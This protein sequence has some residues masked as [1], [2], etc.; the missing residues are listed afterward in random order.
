MERS[1][2][3]RR[4]Q[5]WVYGALLTLGGLVLLLGVALAITSENLKGPLLRVIIAHSGRPVRVDGEFTAHLLARHP[6]ITATQ[7]VIG[8]PAWM[9]PGD[10]AQIG[11]LSIA[12]SWQ[13][14]AIPL[15]IQTLQLENTT[16]H[17]LRDASGHSN[18]HQRQSGPGSG[19]PLLRSLSM[20]EA[21]V[22]LNDERRHLQF[23][24]AVSVTETPTAEGPPS[25]RI[26]ARG[27]LNGRSAVLLIVGDPLALVERA[28]PY[29]FSLEERS[30]S[31]HLSALGSIERPFDFR[32]LQGTFT[33]TGPDMKDLYYLVGLN[34]PETG[35]FR[36]SGKL[37]RQGKRFVYSDLAAHT[38]QSD[39]SGTL[40]VDSSG[41][42]SSVEGELS[43]TA[44]VLAD[45]GARAAGHAAEPVQPAA[46]RVPDTPLRISGLR[47]TDWRLKLRAQALTLGPATLHSV[48]ALL[49]VDQGVLSVER[50]KATLADGTVAGDVRLDAARD[51]PRAELALSLS[52]LQLEQLHGKGSEPPLAGPLSARVQL[53]GE[54]KS[55][56]ELAATANGTMTAVI[57]R[58][59]MR[60]SIAQATGLDL[61]GLLG[62]KA[63]PET[64]IR[65]AVASFDAH[66]G[67]VTVRTFVL[68]TDKMLISGTGEAHMDSET[69]DFVL[70]GRP[71]R[72]SLALHS[73]V[74]LQ[75]TL[76]HPQTRLV[77][78]DVLA[79]A[80][81]AVALAI[82]LTPVAAALAFVNPGL[83]HNADCVA[84][85]AQAKAAPE[86]SP[87]QPAPAPSH[88]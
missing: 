2:A 29:H 30:G 54:G 50:I 18:W 19:P 37:D 6:T 43:S 81:A 24:G 10:T 58:G 35:P 57:P 34:L 79:Q 66:Q 59:A 13:L 27:P 69:L 85:L 7:V 32:A 44:L 40:T 83:A 1:A 23:S 9:P 20:T 14:A 51:L 39:V 15:A 72:V 71:K 78:R 60:S 26:E 11:R 28:R 68:D 75:G 42:R 77:G 65:C 4:V 41:A 12:L 53:S 67:A 76:A 22:E 21:H 87:Q 80:G 36:L 17:L 62:S 64:P 48:T 46:L 61:T 52:E 55:L 25:L 88:K 49:A 56:H 33:A 8:N 16:L 84:L 5:K 73:G 47:R 74:A 63:Q 45:I 70:H 3:V 82:L 31:T 38:G 86:G